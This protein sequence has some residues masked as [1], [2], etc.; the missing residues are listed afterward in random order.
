MCVGVYACA[1][2][3]PQSLKLEEKDV[4]VQ[5]EILKFIREAMIDYYRFLHSLC[6]MN[7]E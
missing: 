6:E 1:R 5:S 3:R 2:A 7:V 4:K